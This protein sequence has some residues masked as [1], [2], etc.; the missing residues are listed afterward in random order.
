M[1]TNRTYFIFLS[2][3]S[4]RRTTTSAA[5]SVPAVIFLSTS[6]ARRTTFRSRLS[7]YRMQAFLSTSS[8]RRTTP[9][10]P[11]GR[12][13][14]YISIHVLREEDDRRC[15]GTTGPTWYFYP[16]PPRGGRRLIFPPILSF[17]VHFYP[18]PPRG[19]R[20]CLQCGTRSSN[21]ISIHVL[22][23]EDDGTRRPSR[24]DS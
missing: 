1:S 22:R 3:S 2:T 4:A 21:W 13:K 24:S 19:G 18:R 10:S 17:R 9:L 12:R 11:Q 7:R 5:F 8:A 23:E 6:S 15:C 20:P 16:R 14:A